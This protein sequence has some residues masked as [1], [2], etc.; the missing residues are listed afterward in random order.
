[1]LSTVQSPLGLTTTQASAD[2]IDQD[3]CA[4]DE[5]AR[6]GAH[7]AV[8]SHIASD[9]FS[10]P[11]L[12][13]IEFAQ[14]QSQVISS[15]QKGSQVLKE[16]QREMPLEKVHSVMDEAREGQLAQRVGRRRSLFW[17]SWRPADK[18]QCLHLLQEIDEA[19]ASQMSPE[20]EEA[21]QAEFAQLQAEIGIQEVSALCLVPSQEAPSKPPFLSGIAGPETRAKPPVGA[22]HRADSHD[23][24]RRGSGGQGPNKTKAAG[25]G[26][27]AGHGQLKRCHRVLRVR[28]L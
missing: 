21:V 2:A 10:T 14:I 7:A 11:Q 9:T 16:L 22:G 15:L 27:Y 13:T 17:R 8:L 18:C 1:M 12:S 5:S 26:S 23:R 19:L 6:A 20:E 3:R 24:A 28:R 25:R 4:A